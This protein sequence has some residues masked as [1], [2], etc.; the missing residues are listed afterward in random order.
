MAMKHG[1]PWFHADLNKLPAF[2]AGM[3]IEDWVSKNEIQILNVAR[4][5]ASKDPLIYGLITLIIELVYT[6][7]IAKDKRPEQTSD[8]LN[9]DRPETTKRLMKLSTDSLLNYP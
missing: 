2:Q 8:I 5:R 9:T 7:A 6:L 4:P 1:K 3:L